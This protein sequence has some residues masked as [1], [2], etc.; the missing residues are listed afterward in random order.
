MFAEFTT[1]AGR[2]LR[3]AVKETLISN[4]NGEFNNQTQVVIAGLTNTYSQYVTTYEE[5]KQ[6]RY[7]AASTL[8]G[9]HT[10][11]AY[12]Q[13]FKKLAQALARGDKKVGRGTSP[14]DLSSVQL[15]LL[16]DPSGDSPP[17]GVRF[18]DMKRDVRG[19][20]FRGG[21]R[22]NATFWSANPRYDLLTEGTFGL[23]EMQKGD[24]WIPVYDDDDLCVY[25][26]WDGPFYDG[27]GGGYGFATV[28]WEVPEGASGGVYRLRHFG[29]FKTTKDSNTS[30]FTGAST[31]FV[32]F[33]D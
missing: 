1:M 22:V 12:I 17:P 23:V 6:Q 26:K 5:Y 21:D 28:E 24:K 9:P 2:R 19:V 33:K 32:V 4:G 8:Y 27:S 20:S 3:E 25:F 11:S 29:A 31:G 15:S 7:E 16:P 30:Y 13:E 18:G 10:L 14:P